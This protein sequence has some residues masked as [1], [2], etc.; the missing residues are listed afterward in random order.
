MKKSSMDLWV[1]GSIL[2]G[3]FIL[4]A[5]ILWL[6]EISVTSK[7]VEYTAIFPTIGTLQLGD[8]VLINGVKKGM[9]AKIMLRGTHVAVILK[10]ENTVPL[11]D[12]S[13]VTVQNVGLMGERAIGITLSDKG[14]R[15]V[16]TNTATHDTTYLRGNFDTGIA[17][18]MGML[19][20]ILTDAQSLLNDVRYIVSTTVGDTL[21]ARQFKTIVARVDKIS[22]QAEQIVDRNTPGINRSLDNVKVIT[23]EIRNLIDTNKAP[24]NTI[25]ADGA[26]IT[27][28]LKTIATRVDSLTVSL[29]DIVA[30]IKRGEGAVGMAIAD[31]DFKNDLKQTVKRVDTLI[32]DAQ[33]GGIPVKVKLF[34]SFKKK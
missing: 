8:P 9:A 18:V 16:P 28:R 10:I 3:V 19:G 13:Y 33:T 6:K 29:Q 30:R 11:S 21:F 25:V 2:I 5:S 17:E 1:G 20:V 24:I 14:N 34:G 23:S 31:E 27:G 7:Q 4:I 22:A 15:L 12:S 32:T 26:E